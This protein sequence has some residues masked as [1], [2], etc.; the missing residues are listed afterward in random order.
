MR[1]VIEI[2]IENLT[3]ERLDEIVLQDEDF[4]TIDSQL[5]DALT[6]YEILGISKQDAKVINEIF[7]LYVAHSARYAALAYRQGLTDSVGLLKNLGII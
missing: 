2:I 1:D 6:H 3:N 7:D 4:C 5:D